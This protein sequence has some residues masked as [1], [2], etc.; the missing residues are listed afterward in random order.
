MA[1]P[2]EAPVPAA[3]SLLR[4]RSASPDVPAD[5]RDRLA[6]AL[7]TDDLVVALRWAKEL[8]PWFGVVKVGLELFSA[9]RPDAVASMADHGFKVFLDL[10]LYDIPTTVRRAARLLGEL[11]ATYVTLHAHAGPVMLRAGVD[12][13]NE[14]AAAAERPKPC[15]L[16]V[17]LLTS[18]RGAPAHI[19]GQRVTAAVQGGCGGV[20]CAGED[21]REAKQLAPR[22]LVVV[23]GIRM[24]GSDA[25]DQ[26]R[27]A[28]PRQALDAGADLI[29]VGRA[30]TQA[31]DRAKAAA[32]LVDSI[33][34]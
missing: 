32:A 1:V 14:G 27:T 18:D 25:H 34:A 13:L 17:T 15:A 11:V 26:A 30:V 22:L 8:Q 12:G 6:L 7:D 9:A 10:K 2:P 23:P 24:E 20:V 5:V 21:I 3:E 16:A 31:D 28:T 29:V 4:Y 19:L 33:G